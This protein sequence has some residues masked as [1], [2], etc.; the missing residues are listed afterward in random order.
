M[1]ACV[2]GIVWEELSAGAAS[3]KSDSMQVMEG[4]PRTAEVY[5][6]CESTRLPGVGWGELLARDRYCE[7]TG[8]TSFTVSGGSV[9]FNPFEPAPRKI[10][11]QTQHPVRLTYPVHSQGKDSDCLHDSRSAGV[12]DHNRLCAIK[13]EWTPS[14]DALP[15][16]HA[17][18][19]AQA[20]ARARTRVHEH[21]RMRTQTHR[22]KHAST[23]TP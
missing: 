9:Q 11:R 10:N 8:L 23:S 16:P 2:R 7:R 13:Q 19:H 4:A 6:M 3:N 5:K 12:R 17:R 20:C 18:T 15:P 1:F 22:E 21:T 14:E